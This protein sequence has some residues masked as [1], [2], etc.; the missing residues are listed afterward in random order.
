MTHIKICWFSYEYSIPWD[1]E[2]KEDKL[3]TVLKT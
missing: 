3:I 2:L 1:R